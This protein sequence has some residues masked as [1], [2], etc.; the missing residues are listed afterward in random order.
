MS[1][2]LCP[3]AQLHLDDAC[4]SFDNLRQPVDQGSRATAIAQAAPPVSGFTVSADLIRGL[5][6][7]ATRCGVARARLCDM[8]NGDRSPACA[9]SPPTR[10]SGGHILKLWDRIVRETGDPII[11]FRMALVAGV[12]TF[13]VLGQILPRC[14]TVLEA[15]RQ[16]SRYSAIASQG[17]QVS[18][19]SDGDALIASLAMPY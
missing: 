5:V 13:G 11:G 19:T 2:N 17:A 16:T 3:A 14:A 4:Q 12:K 10:Y 6:D 7:C 1:R 9:S 15:Y 8:I 18:V